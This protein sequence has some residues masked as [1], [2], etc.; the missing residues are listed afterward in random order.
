MAKLLARNNRLKSRNGRL[1]RNDPACKA[2]CCGGGGGPCCDARRYP[3]DNGPHSCGTLTS[4]ASFCVVEYRQREVQSSESTVNTNDGASFFNQ[5]T[6]ATE[7]LLNGP[8][9]GLGTCSVG[10]AVP[11]RE[12]YITEWL[13][14]GTGTTGD[15]SEERGGDGGA[16][17]RCVQ[18]RGE[19]WPVGSYHVGPFEA[20][21]FW[22]GLPFVG[23]SRSFDETT[24][25]P[26]G[27]V[28][29]T[30]QI[31]AIEWT[32][33]GRTLTVEWSL[34]RTVTTSFTSP[35]GGSSNSRTTLAVTGRVTGHSGWSVNCD[36]TDGPY[37]CAP[38]VTDCEP[39]LISFIVGV[40]CG[41]ATARPFVLP[42][43]NVFQ[44]GYVN[45]NGVCYQFSPNGRRIRDPVAL[46]AI[47]GTQLVN[48][49]SPQSCCEC[50]LTCPKTD[51]ASDGRKDGVWL[52][53]VRDGLTGAWSTSPA[54]TAGACCCFPADRFRVRTGYTTYT[55]RSGGNVAYTERLDMV[56]ETSGEIDPTTGNPYPNPI[57]G[58]R[59]DVGNVRYSQNYV[60]SLGGSIPQFGRY[61]FTGPVGCEYSGFGAAGG[62][63][64]WSLGA[65]LDWD[66]NHTRI[67][68]L[69][70]PAA[71]NANGEA[72]G[73]RLMR[74]ALSATCTGMTA[75]A[76]W[77]Q[78]RDDGE[79]Y[80]VD[81]HLV[82]DVVR[83]DTPGPC[84]GGCG[85]LDFVPP[86]TPVPPGGIVSDVPDLR[87]ILGGV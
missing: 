20:F 26:N 12:T 32:S 55:E 84:T 69:Q 13:V 25:D 76:L 52:N 63:S 30:V 73:W 79:V 35:G 80:S 24:T 19:C 59:R 70:P 53:G 8:N 5:S 62:A 60:N 34:N 38:V 50:S 29:R 66:G 18:V 48:Q 71:S 65:P 78:I 41:P 57:A 27:T 40:P 87:S 39:D 28:T 15:T 4:P 17:E 74:Y 58:F 36:G 67:F 1:V 72:N 75:D 37:G 44:C 54:F 61:E 6:T 2:A 7:W 68:R 83:D 86:A 81:A 10:F 33:D 21:P 85:V 42:V 46:N 47:V 77:H 64:V 51:L 49:Y 14:R 56:P 31:A 3:G 22:Q 43:G 16:I 45:L 9:Y 23:D 82:L 11:I